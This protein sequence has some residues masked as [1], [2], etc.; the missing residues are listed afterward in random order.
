MIDDNYDADLEIYVQYGEGDCHKRVEVLSGR[1]S[2]IR[3]DATDGAGDILSGI[4]RCLL[5]LTMS[6]TTN[7][8]ML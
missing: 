1:S 8:V 6:D 4:P 3:E 2:S 7:A 5:S